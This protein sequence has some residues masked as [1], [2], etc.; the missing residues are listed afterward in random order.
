MLAEQYFVIY[1]VCYMIRIYEVTEVVNRNWNR[2]RTAGRGD[3]AQWD[4]AMRGEEFLDICGTA[5]YLAI[6][7]ML[8]CTYQSLLRG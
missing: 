2:H 4:P 8:Y 7:L 1:I 3:A 6:M 5:L